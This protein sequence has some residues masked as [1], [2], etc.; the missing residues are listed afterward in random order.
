MLH[1]VIKF[2]IP[3]GDE[4]FYGDQVEAKQFYLAM[5]STKVAMKELQLVEEEQEILEDVG[6][7]PKANVMED[8]IRYELDEPSSYHLFLTGENLNERERTE[9][10]EFLKANVKFFAWTPYEMP[11]IDQNFIK[12]KLNVTPKARPVK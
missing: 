5:V 10:I 4:A 8:F 9:L 12:H 7:T 3:R 11:G 2:A 1:Q 6:S